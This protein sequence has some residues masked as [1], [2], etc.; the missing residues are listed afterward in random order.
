MKKSELLQEIDDLITQEEVSKNS[1]LLSIFVKG[2]EQIVSDSSVALGQ[3]SQAISLYL[4][5]HSYQA[6]KEV[7]EFSTKIAKAPH[8]ERGKGAFLKMLAMSFVG[9]K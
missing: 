1:E 9:L 8:Q 3:L 7:I 2:R 6:P 5:Q 4:M